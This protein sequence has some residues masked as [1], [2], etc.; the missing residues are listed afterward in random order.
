MENKIVLTDGKGDELNFYILE[1]AQVKGVNYI[2]VTD[3]EDGEGDGTCYILKEVED[4]DEE[5]VYEFVDNDNE[6]DQAYEVFRSL[7]EDADLI[8]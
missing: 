3:E 6:M 7:M 5:V 4:T 1:R 2:L 8:K